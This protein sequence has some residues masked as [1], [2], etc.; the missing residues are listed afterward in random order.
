MNQLSMEN[1]FKFDDWRKTIT[2]VEKEQGWKYTDEQLK[3]IELALTN[4]VIMI[5]GGAGTGKSSIVNGIIRVLKA[6]DYKQCALS[7]KA[8][9]RMAEITGETGYTIHR[10]LGYNPDRGF[11][12]NAKTRLPTEIVILDEV[13]MIGGFLFHSLINAIET[14]SKLIVLGDV[15]QLESIG[16]MNIAKDI[17]E[18]KYI[19]SIELTKI[20]RQAQKSGI[21]TESIKVRNKQPLFENGWIGHDV[22]GILQD[23]EL[24]VYDDKQKSVEKCLSYFKKYLSNESNITEIKVLVTT[25]ERGEASVF[26]LNNEIQEIYNPHK[27]GKNEVWITLGKNKKFAIR[28]GDKVMVVRN[29]YRTVNEDGL[30]TPIFN[31][32][33]GIVKEIDLESGHMYVDMPYISDRLII[34]EKSAWSNLLLGYATTIAKSQ[35]SQFEYVIGCIDYST[36]PM[37]LTKE[38]I[39]TL[40]TRASKHCVLLGES[41]ALRRAMTTSFIST[42]RTFLKEMLDG[43]LKDNIKKNN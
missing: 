12:Y 18:S 38:L 4:Q 35:G 9:S 11:A 25:K 6:Y 34:I 36:P 16:C 42:K 13:S 17:L 14:G 15:H 29:N 22:R 41:K 20:H 7:G 43:E 23:F 10:L 2:E 8:A 32:Q 5:T 37:M 33:Q 3:A 40:M 27:E 31:G 30:Q 39:Y 28:E 1:E 19:I 21:P 24:D 26:N